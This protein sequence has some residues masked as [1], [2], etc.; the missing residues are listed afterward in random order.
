MALD[1]AHGLD[2]MH[3]N[4]FIHPDLAARNCLVGNNGQIVIGDYGLTP[5]KYKA[6]YY[7]RASVGIPIR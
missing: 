5:Q 6:E 3:K 7:W 1:I 4:N 2:W